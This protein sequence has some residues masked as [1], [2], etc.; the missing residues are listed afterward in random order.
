LKLEEDGWVIG[1]LD[2]GERKR[3]VEEGKGKRGRGP[4]EAEGE[5]KGE[6][7]KEGA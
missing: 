3:K 7:H 1:Y 4:D 2:E 5:R 6:E